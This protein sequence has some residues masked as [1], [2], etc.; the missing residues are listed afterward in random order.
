MS[1]ARST[2]IRGPAKIRA[3]RR[4]RAR[5]SATVATS[6][7]PVKPLEPKADLHLRAELLAV[8]AD[9]PAAERAQE[10]SG[11]LRDRARDAALES[12]AQRGGA[13]DDHQPV[14]PLTAAAT[15]AANSSTSSGAVS[16]AHIQRTSSALSSQT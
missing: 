2:S 4:R 16:H 15:A 12:V 7:P 6:E 11:K 14:A 8:D 3:S 1:D 10:R 5:F 13:G 9:R